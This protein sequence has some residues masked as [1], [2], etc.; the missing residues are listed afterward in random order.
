M[1]PG[2][3]FTIEVGKSSRGMIFVTLTSSKPCLIQGS[4]PRSWIFPDGW[5]ASTEV[6]SLLRLP[7]FR[8]VHLLR[9]LELCQECTEGAYGSDRESRCGGHYLGSIGQV[10]KCIAT[11]VLIGCRLVS[12][13]PNV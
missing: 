5:T 1:L 6:T 11:V 7:S 8:I 4:N 10:V 13:M 12:F 9:Q 3:C 2:H